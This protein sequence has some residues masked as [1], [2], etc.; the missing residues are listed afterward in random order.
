M[1]TSAVSF[2]RKSWFMGLFSSGKYTTT[3]KYA[4]GY[5]RTM[6]IILH[7]VFTTYSLWVIA[8]FKNYARHSWEIIDQRRPPPLPF[9]VIV[10]NSDTLFS[11]EGGISVALRGRCI[12]DFRGVNCT[13]W[14]LK[15]SQ[16]FRKD[17]SFFF[18]WGGGGL[19]P[20][21][22]SKFNTATFLF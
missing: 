4:Q 15:T 1:D 20:W 22:P 2:T 9:L 16:I 11:R 21:L 13:F 19:I 12:I 5:S 10:L 6:S 3:E 18:L 14:I 8:S 17:I 7:Y